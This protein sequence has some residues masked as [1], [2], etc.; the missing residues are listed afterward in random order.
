MLVAIYTRVSTQH[1]NDEPQVHQLLD[2]CKRA[3]WTVVKVYRETVSGT[4][5]PTD[6]AVLR[7][8]LQ[9]ARKRRFEKVVVWSADRLARSMTHLVAV[10]GE[11]HSLNIH[12]HSHLQAIDT[13]TP[14][15]SALWS[16]LGVFS[17][18]ENA[19]RRERQTLG[20]ARAKERG[21]QFGRKPMNWMVREQVLKLRKGGMGI[22]RIAKKLSVGSG[23]VHRVLKDE[24]LSIL[25][26]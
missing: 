14:M 4:K 10:L 2:V 26:H 3:G 17:E 18:F 22:N 19:I 16:M 5:G 24:G 13:S 8:L 9:D 20:I 6:R 12:L 15:G 25:G 7:E 11:L 21:V 1:Q 23:A